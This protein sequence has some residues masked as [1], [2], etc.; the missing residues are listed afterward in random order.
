ML[1]AAGDL[2]LD[3]ELLELLADVAGG[4]VD[5]PLPLGAL[6]GDQPLD[7]VVLAR[8]Q[9]LEREV[10]KLPLDR[11]DTEPVRDRGVD[12]ERLASL[13]DLL[14]LSHGRDRAHVVQAVGELDQDDPDVR[15]H[16]DHHLAVV[17]RLRLVAR[18]ERQAGELGD[19]VDEAGDLLA[20][21]LLHLL[22]RRRGVLDGVVQER[23]AQRFGVE[24]HPRADLRHADGVNDE[25]LAGLPALIGVVHACVHERFLDPVAVD[26]GGGLVGVLLD[27][28]E[29]VAE[30]PPLGRGQLGPLDYLAVSICLRDPVYRRPGA[31]EQRRARRLTAVRTRPVLLAGPAQPPRR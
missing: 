23:R 26:H 1:G 2:R 16:R 18:L 27:D 3:P 20:E 31:R 21:R 28:R 7:L 8:V 9:S 12:V 30:Q 6:L 22:E 10:L 29:Q 24:P 19:A 14:L 15:G 4:L 25:V 17:L 11:M 13:I 5:V